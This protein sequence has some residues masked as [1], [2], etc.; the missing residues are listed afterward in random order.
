MLCSGLLKPSRTNTLA[1]LPSL[2]MIF[3]SAIPLPSASPSGLRCDVMRKRRPARMRSAT[4]RAALS[5][6]VVAVVVVVIGF[7]R[8]HFGEDAL[9]ATGAHR[10]FVVSKVEL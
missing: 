6:F 9:D 4:S 5:G 10:R 8:H 7:L 1:S 3:C 2:R